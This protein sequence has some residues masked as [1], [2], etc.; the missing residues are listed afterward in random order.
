MERTAALLSK[1]IGYYKN[2]MLIQPLNERQQRKLEEYTQALEEIKEQRFAENLEEKKAQIEQRLEI[3]RARSRNKPRYVIGDLRFKTQ[4]EAYE[5]YTNYMMTHKEIEE[6][7]AENITALVKR[8]PEF[9]FDETKH[10][11][12][13]ET[14]YDPPGN[15]R[16]FALRDKST[17]KVIQYLSLKTL[18]RRP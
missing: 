18:V 2:I 16:S 12:S 7:D 6:K 4:R 11:I 14:N 10:T 9:G 8:H 15:I 17:D 13:I 3:N 1:R 5:Y